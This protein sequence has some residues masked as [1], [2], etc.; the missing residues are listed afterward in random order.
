MSQ[1]R[2]IKC[3][4]C[5]KWTMWDGK[6]DDRCLYCNEFLEPDR[7]SREVENKINDEL[8]KEYD[9]FFIK[10]TDGPIKRGIKRFFN[11]FRWLVYYAQILVF[12]FVTL[13]LV[14]ISLFSV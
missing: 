8:L 1:I 11:S 10:P 12:L 3:P 9:Y 4:N 14:L 6:V 13:I 5:G 7:F 2:E